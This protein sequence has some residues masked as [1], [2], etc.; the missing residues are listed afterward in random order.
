MLKLIDLNPKS[1]PH[2]AIYDRTL[3]SKCDVSSNNPV[4]ANGCT[5]LWVRPD[6]DGQVEQM[7]RRRFHGLDRSTWKHFKTANSSSITL[8]DPLSTPYKHS[9][10]G[11]ETPLDASQ[12]SDSPDMTVYFSRVGF[13][14]KKN[15]ALVYVLAFSYLGRTA[16]TGDYLRFRLG[17]D[18]SWTVAGRVRY[19]HLDDDIFVRLHRDAVSE[20]SVNV[21]APSFS[22]APGCLTF[23]Y[24]RQM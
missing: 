21:G 11:A 16:A 2:V 24:R 22:I 12:Q 13:N 14:S 7:L 15:E 23:V 1:D 5:F 3:S 18:K 19:M 4:F 9:I 6:T 10:V 8:H 17:P 20:A